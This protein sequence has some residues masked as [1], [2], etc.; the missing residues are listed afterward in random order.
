MRENPL[1]NAIDGVKLPLGCALGYNLVQ[2][3]KSSPVEALGGG[4]RA[5]GQRK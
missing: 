2:A 5:M 1:Y 4:D 3:G